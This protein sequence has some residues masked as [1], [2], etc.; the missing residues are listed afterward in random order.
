MANSSFEAKFGQLSDTQIHEKVPV[1]SPYKIGFQTVDKDD[2]E[3]R[4]VGVMVYKVGK[5]WVYIPAFW[6][7]GRLK[8]ADM[9][10]LKQQDMFLPLDEGWV[11]YIKSQHPIVSGKGS[12]KNGKDR[13]PKRDGSPASVS[14]R[15]LSTFGHNKYASEFCL[16]DE[17]TLK[18]MMHQPRQL[19]DV[20]LH[21]WLPRMGK[22]AALDLIET[23][24]TDNKFASAVMQFY[25]IKEMQKIAEVVEEADKD[26]TQTA[27]TE[28]KIITDPK[29]DEAGYLDEPAKQVLIRDGVFVVDE[30]KDTSDVFAEEVDTHTLE[31]PKITGIYD[32]L[33]YDG[34]YKRMLVIIPDQKLERTCDSSHHK[35]KAFLCDPE[36]D[37]DRL[38]CVCAKDIQARPAVADGNTKLPELT[39]FGSLIDNDFLAKCGS[40]VIMDP[41]GTTVCGTM[42]YGTEGPVFRAYAT[43]DKGISKDIKVVPTHKSGNL[44]MGRDTL[45]IPNDC[46]G[47]ETSSGT[48]EEAQLGT[49]NTALFKIASHKEVQRVKIFND[50][51]RYHITDNDKTHGSLSK[52]AALG[53]LINRYGVAAP[54]AKLM[55]KEA[56]DKKTSRYMIKIASE[57]E[58]AVNK[59]DE[60]G[61]DLIH[62]F[63]TYKPTPID[64]GASAKVQEAASMGVKDVMDTTVLQTLAKRKNTMGMLSDYMPDLVKAVDRLGRLLFL[65]YWHNEDFQNKY[66]KQKMYD[67]EQ[68]LKDVFDSLSDTVIF[69]K[70][71]TTEEGMVMSEDEDG[72]GDE[73]GTI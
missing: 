28:V 23:L 42:G 1:L 38:S 3:T 36:G 15:P 63:K 41:K 55:L 9:M 45:Y 44:I 73:V 25:N 14:M 58:D 20:S 24:K 13:D 71:R 5:Q 21:T 4:A 60:R 51:L 26:N 70:E 61:D 16:L 53:R 72:L 34:S 48:A 56:C 31:S 46:K 32:V 43:T 30:R 8:A 37:K 59:Q 12:R 10:Y 2:D 66:G 68:S 40:C 50:G 22:E 7:N 17:D 49:V 52:V 65:F 33:M 18:N 27:K 19:A 47:F 67:L 57:Y 69:L 35:G 6:L 54:S 11:S 29:S 64:S 62:Q 39:S